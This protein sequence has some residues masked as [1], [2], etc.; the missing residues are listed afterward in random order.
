MNDRQR[1]TVWE[2]SIIYSPSHLQLIALSATIANADELTDWIRWVHGPTRLITS[3][4]RPVP[5]RFS[6]ITA[7]GFYPL[8]NPQQNKI[9]PKLRVQSRKTNTKKQKRSEM[10]SIANVVRHLHQR[11]LLPTI[12]FIFSRKRCEQAL[13]QVIHLK[14][15][16]ADEAVEIERQIQ[17]RLKLNSNLQNLH[18][19]MPSGLEWPV[20]MRDCCRFGKTLWRSYFS[21]G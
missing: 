8:L 2:E 1:G 12:Y 17:R 14:L 7:N 9:N 6:F 11:D 15:L 19:S 10:P 18:N 3:T 16:T 21:W 13:N 4:L 20:T 5:L